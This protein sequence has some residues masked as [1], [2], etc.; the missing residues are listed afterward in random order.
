MR[1]AVW[2]GSGCDLVD[3]V[4][5]LRHGHRYRG[6]G[7]CVA[8]TLS[9]T[10]NP[11]IVISTASPLPGTDSGLSYSQTLASSGGTGTVTWSSTNLPL[12]AQVIVGTER[13]VGPR[14]SVT[15]ATPYNFNV[16]V[17]D[18]VRL[19]G[20]KAFSVTVN[21]LP[22][23]TS[24][25]P[26]PTWTVG[27]PYTQTLAVAGG[28]APLTFADSGTTLPDWLTIT[29]TG[30]L[31]GTP[32]A[33][34]PVSFTVRVTDILSSS[35]TKTF[36]LTINPAPSVTTTSLPAGMSGGP[37]SQTLAE[38]S[39]TTPFTWQA[40][41]LPTWLSLSSSGTLSGTA[42]VVSSATPFS[43]SVTVTDAA[44]A[45]SASQ[46]LAVTVNPAVQIT[47]ARSPARYRIRA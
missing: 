39:G 34:G 2:D 7:E 43:F 12:V 31:S 10:V 13:S 14:L 8:K 17:T 6:R 9:V 11:G 16:T 36:A 45:V 46:N 33:A 27:R 47:T 4:Q 30:V 15:T 22:T 24:A 1:G 23:L 5:L 19:T 37:Y 32:T 40:S 25:S 3:P 42:P 29:S 38:S 44:G 35:T 26:L 21:P 28:T 20:N 18:S 41:G